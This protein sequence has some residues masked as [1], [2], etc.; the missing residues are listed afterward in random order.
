MTSPTCPECG[1]P[2]PATGKPATGKPATGMPATGGN[3]EYWIDS[4]P[5]G[6]WY[7]QLEVHECSC[8]HIDFVHVENFFIPDT[9]H[10]EYRDR[11]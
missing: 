3:V 6:E 4:E 11:P 2:M 1:E 9:S 8:G 5:T 10:D 7:E